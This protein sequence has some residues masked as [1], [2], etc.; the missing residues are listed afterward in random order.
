MTVYEKDAG[1]L[2]NHYIHTIIAY[3]F[4]LEINIQ[5]KIYYLCFYR[6]EWCGVHFPVH[7][8]CLILIR[9]EYTGST[10]LYWNNLEN[11]HLLKR[12]RYFAKA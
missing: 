2:P 10:T 8:T 9:V 4:N 11:G 6:Y 5:S 1:Y 12:C 3:I 7:P